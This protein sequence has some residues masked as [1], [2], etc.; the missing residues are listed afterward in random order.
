[1][2]QADLARLVLDPFEGARRLRQGRLEHASV[3]GRGVRGH[4]AGSPV[5]LRPAE[6]P[7]RRAHEPPRRREAQR[8]LV[9]PGRERAD[10]FEVCRSQPL[11]DEP[12]RHPP[13][14]RADPRLGHARGR[15]DGQ[16]LAVARGHRLGHAERGVAPQRGQPLH[17][18]AHLLG[19]PRASLDAQDA[20]SVGSLDPEG[21]VREPDAQQRHWRCLEPVR[22]QRCPR[23][24]GEATGP[25]ALVER[26]DVSSHD[27]SSSHR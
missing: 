6:C 3:F 21:R 13:E 12:P 20:R 4:D 17:L 11:A 19:P 15:R 14:Q 25:G 5:D 26:R 18:R 7:D 27:Q 22:R 8:V 23:E 24:Y 2:D 9:Q 16:Q 10:P 1:M